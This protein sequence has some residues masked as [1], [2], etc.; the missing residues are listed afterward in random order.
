MN[1]VLPNA[2]LLVLLYT[3]TEQLSVV[4]N[5]TDVGMR[6]NPDPIRRNVWKINAPIQFFFRP[7]M[8]G[9]YFHEKEESQSLKIPKE[10]NKLF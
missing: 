10:I 8:T 7:K 4:K 9:R 6:F 1:G 5:T 2:V 3:D